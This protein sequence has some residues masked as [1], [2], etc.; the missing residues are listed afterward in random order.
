MQQ[1]LLFERTNLTIIFIPSTIPL[2]LQDDPVDFK[3]PKFLSTSNPR[4]I[5]AGLS[6]QVIDVLSGKGI[7]HFTPVQGEA[8]GPIMARRDVI[9]RSRTGTGKTLA[10]GLP[11]L[12]RLIE[13]CNANGKRDPSTGRMRR[14]RSVSM[15]VLCPTRELARQVADEL[16]EVAQPLRLF[17]ECFHGGVSYGPQAGALRD[18][19]D[20]LVGTPGRVIDHMQRGNL[21]LSEC[22]IAVLDEADEMLNMGF[23]DGTFFWSFCDV[24][25]L[26]FVRACICL[27]LI[28]AV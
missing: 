28:H 18:G 2:I 5:Q 11:T 7:T 25:L 21:N 24:L 14:G 3:D 10:F 26:L 22:D 19:L 6:Q 17:V 27:I 13:F 1:K 15:I 23:A 12:T 20:V 4:W 16:K 8:F 9:G